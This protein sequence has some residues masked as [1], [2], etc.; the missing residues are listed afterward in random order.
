MIFTK[1]IIDLIKE[2]RRH[3]PAEMKPGIKLA[4]PEVLDEIIIL[5]HESNDTI[6]RALVKELC[7]LAGSEW[8]DRLIVP[9]KEEQR[10]VTKVY[11][12]QTE[13]V[14]VQSESTEEISS[15]KPVRVY[16]GA[17]VQ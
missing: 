10:Y 14:P 8:S 15:S 3:V 16:R 11:R 7:F 12:G 2:I 1:P 5:Y 4:N 17:I 6:L 9:Q 13:L